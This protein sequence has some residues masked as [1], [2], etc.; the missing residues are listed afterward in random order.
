MCSP[1]SEGGRWEEGLIGGKGTQDK[2][3]WRPAG[4]FCGPR[5]QCPGQP[6]QFGP[7]SKF[8]QPL[9]DR[10]ARVDCREFGQH[11]INNVRTE[12]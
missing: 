4:D 8:L 7:I 9:S 10:K 2:S 11:Y 5:G 6:P 1:N 12:G 3:P